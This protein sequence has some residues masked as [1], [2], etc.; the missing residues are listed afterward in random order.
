MIE[1]RGGPGLHALTPV[2]AE[3]GDLNVVI[4]TPKGKRNKYTYDERHHLFR[5]SGMLPVG[6]I[7]PWDFGFLP[8]TRA[9]DGDPIDV[10]VLMEEAA[11]PG[12][13]VPARAIGVI[14]AEQ[15][16]R[17]GVTTRNDRL[18]TVATDDPLYA[19][20]GSLADL[21]TLLVE[22]I[23]HFFASYN[24]IKGKQFRTCGRGDAERAGALIREAHTRYLRE[25]EMKSSR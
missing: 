9:D 11:F 16:E 6:A 19:A 15:T 23:E 21:A 8:A 10:L 24:A 22:Q 7:F 14:E 12:C 1:S 3:S 25:G 5:L 2:D 13:L 18:I 20:I 17:D 4:E